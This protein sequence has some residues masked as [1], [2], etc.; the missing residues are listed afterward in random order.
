[1]KSSVLAAAIIF[2][3]SPTLA[4]DC[5]LD[6]AIYTDRTGYTLAFRPVTREEELAVSNAFALT[7][8]SGNTVLE[9]VVTW[10]NGFTRPIGRLL[11]GCPPEPTYEQEETCTHWRG[12]IYGVT[13][14]TVD[15]LAVSDQP[16]ADQVI[17][18]NLGQTL[19]YSLFSSLVEEPINEMPWDVFAFKECRP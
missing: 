5:R 1:M 19:N 13:G 18:S 10:G 2:A 12:I 3:S 17:L 15:L 14:T 7:L 6:H 4:V 9:G 16:A 8:P 11:F